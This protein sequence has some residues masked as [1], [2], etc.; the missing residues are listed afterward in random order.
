[1]IAVNEHP[2]GV[3]LA[4]RAHPGAKRNELRE[5]HD[6]EIRVAVTA[7]PDK[8]R[9]NQAIVEFLARELNLRRSQF[10]LLTG[11][12][13]RSKRFLV[14]GVSAAH[15]IGLLRA[16]LEPTVASPPEESA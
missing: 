15:L 4:V 3:V 13:A 11:E 6:G 8:G 9:A 16:A 14:T 2:R 7:P 5:G 10:E 12:T 1:M